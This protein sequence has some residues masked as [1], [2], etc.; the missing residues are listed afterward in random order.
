MPY[1]DILYDVQGAV[2]IV[3]LNRPDRMNALT[4]ATHGELARAI[5]EAAGFHGKIA[6]ARGGPATCSGSVPRG[7]CPTVTWTGSRCR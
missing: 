1:K 5:D 2:A 7:K 3:T 6:A 4:L